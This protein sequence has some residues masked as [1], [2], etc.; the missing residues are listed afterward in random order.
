MDGLQD[1]VFRITVEGTPAL[2]INN[3]IKSVGNIPPRYKI[4]EWLNE[5]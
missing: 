4:I 5:I 1:K 3:K 2:I